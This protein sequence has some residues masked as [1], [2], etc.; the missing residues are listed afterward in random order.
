[1]HPGRTRDCQ[2]NNRWPI[3]SL[4]SPQDG[5]DGGP[6]AQRAEPT[7][8]AVG[9]PPCATTRTVG[10][11]NEPGVSTAAHAPATD[12]APSPPLTVCTPP[13]PSSP[14]TPPISNTPTHTQCPSRRDP[15]DAAAAAAAPTPTAPPESDAGVV[16]AFRSLLPP[17]PPPAGDDD[18]VDLASPDYWR[19]E[20]TAELRRP[21][22]S[23]A[24]LWRELLAPAMGAPADYGVTFCPAPSQEATIKAI[25][26]A[27]GKAGTALFQPIMDRH[28][29]QDPSTPGWSQR[30]DE[31]DVT[32]RLLDTFSTE[33]G[34]DLYQRSDWCEY[35]HPNKLTFRVLICFSLA[36]ACAGGGPM[37][38]TLWSPPPSIH[39]LLAA[40]SRGR[41]SPRTM[42]N[43]DL[44]PSPMYCSPPPHRFTMTSTY[45]LR[46]CDHIVFQR[47]V[48]TDQQRHG[49]QPVDDLADANGEPLTWVCAESKCN[50]KFALTV[51]ERLRMNGRCSRPHPEADALTPT[52]AF[53]CSEAEVPLAVRGAVRRLVN[54]DKE[55]WGPVLERLN[56]RPETMDVWV[57]HVRAYSE[58]PTGRARPVRAGAT[59]TNRAA[60]RHALGMGRAS[61]GDACGGGRVA[62]HGRRAVARAAHGRVGGRDG[63]EHPHVDD[64]DAGPRPA[65]QTGC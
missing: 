1:M 61:P 48:V 12:R 28:R 63:R 45:S 6:E 62:G 33:L 35:V 2:H 64:P 38:V 49:V 55:V 52:T 34:E 60:G 22:Y 65:L 7:P 30:D 36:A 24:R 25:L 4:R 11:P 51:S 41:G 40:P 13:L 58:E 59:A 44:P 21:G 54:T 50:T 37:R 18:V 10:D 8:E 43:T 53:A 57:A 19:R 42:D 47:L 20:L 32:K 29:A 3:P 23:F 15:Q 39:A 14:S 16:A 31:V 17:A 26:R 5:R 9:A 56:V 46:L 27:V